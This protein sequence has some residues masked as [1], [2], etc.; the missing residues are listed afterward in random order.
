MKINFYIYFGCTMFN[1]WNL[2]IAIAAGSGIAIAI[3]G[4]AFGICA[5][6]CFLSID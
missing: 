1:I 4:I 5:T 6:L 2:A 3:S